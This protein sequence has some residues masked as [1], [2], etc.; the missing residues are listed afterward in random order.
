[1]CRSDWATHGDHFTCNKYNLKKSDMKNALDIPAE[2]RE[3]V[4]SEEER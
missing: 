2:S 4:T 3:R 1:M